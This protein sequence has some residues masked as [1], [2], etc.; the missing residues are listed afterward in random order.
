[1][2]STRYTRTTETTTKTWLIKNNF[3]CDELLFLQKKCTYHWTK[4]NK[5]YKHKITRIIIKVL[6]RKGGY[7]YSIA[8]IG[9]T[10]KLYD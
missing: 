3:H 7:I 2:K 8:L 9:Q 6:K 5:C 1:M 10:F 4:S